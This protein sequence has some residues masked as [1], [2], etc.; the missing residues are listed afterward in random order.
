M[1]PKMDP[2]DFPTL[3]AAEDAE[4][5]KGYNKIKHLYQEEPSCRRAIFDEER[6]MMSIAL[7]I[8]TYANGDNW[9]IGA[10]QDHGPLLVGETRTKAERVQAILRARRANFMRETGLYDRCEIETV[11]L[12]FH[13]HLF[14]LGALLTE[15]GGIPGCPGPLT[16]LQRQTCRASAEAMQDS[17]VELHRRRMKHSGDKSEN[18]LQSGQ[19]YTD[20][21]ILLAAAELNK[22]CDGQT[23]S[24]FAI[25]QYDDLY[26][27]D[28][29]VAP[30]PKGI[31]INN[32]P[33]TTPTPVTVQHVPITP[34]W[35]PNVKRV[36]GDLCIKAKTFMRGRSTSTL[37]CPEETCP[38]GSKFL[39]ELKPK[40]HLRPDHPA[41]DRLTFKDAGA[42]SNMRNGICDL[43]FEGAKKMWHLDSMANWEGI[44]ADMA[45]HGFIKGIKGHNSMTVGVENYARGDMDPGPPHSNGK[46]RRAFTVVHLGSPTG[47]ILAVHCQFNGRKYEGHEIPDEMKELLRDKD[48][49]KIQFGI[50]DVLE[51]L[52]AGGVMVQNWVEAKNLTMIAYPQPGVPCSQMKSG[53]PFVADS[54]THQRKC[55]AY[56][57]GIVT[58]ERPEQRVQDQSLKVKKSRLTSQMFEVTWQRHHSTTP[59][60]G[61]NGETIGIRPTTNSTCP[62]IS[63]VMTS[64]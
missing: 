1:Y 39:L 23:L 57:Q 16:S 30:R 13:G 42:K 9:C 61:S 31:M 63:T 33:E 38:L 15:S 20:Q 24:K 49:A 2:I 58:T 22:H 43:R 47:G 10:R 7:R 21:N 6:L 46:P 17:M 5:L 62:L 28:A 11:A 8:K 27:I 18:V 4:I 59:R 48:V 3:E 54:L 51:K 29:D 50:K 35:F 40:D 53:R 41:L 56:K 34:E 64:P 14:N 26:G 44:N 36:Q 12:T 52:A 25:K 19:K 37:E 55:T 60:K 32:A 45:G